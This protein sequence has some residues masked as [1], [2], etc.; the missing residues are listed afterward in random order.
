MASVLDK[1]KEVITKK[2]PGMS[3][4]GPDQSAL[5]E[6]SEATVTGYE[7]KYGK[8]S[9]DYQAP[10]V[11]DNMAGMGPDQGALST[12]NRPSDA[13]LEGYEKKYGKPNEEATRTM[14]EGSS[15]GQ[16]MSGIGPDQSALGEG[17]PSDSKEL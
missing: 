1:V 4:M 2:A 11:H 17:M 9:E 15:H 6:N 5:D 8:P 14:S 10:T 16:D 12:E 13:T 3:G 7:K